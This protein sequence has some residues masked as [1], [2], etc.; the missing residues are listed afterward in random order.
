MNSKDADLSGYVM[1]EQVKSIDFKSRKIKFVEPLS[2][3]T[4]DDVLGIL[5]ACVYQ[6]V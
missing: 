2:K 3:S 6:D 4:L 5:D 1:V